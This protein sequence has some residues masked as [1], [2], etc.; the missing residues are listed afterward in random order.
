VSLRRPLGCRLPTLVD[1]SQDIDTDGVDSWV[2]FEMI[3]EDPTNVWL[4]GI[5]RYQISAHNWSV[6]G[7]IEAFL[8]EPESQVM[9][10][11]RRRKVNNRSVLSLCGLWKERHEPWMR[12]TKV[13]IRLNLYT[14]VQR[15]VKTYKSVSFVASR[16]KVKILPF[17]VSLIIRSKAVVTG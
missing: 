12:M 17:P 16:E 13:G 15:V 10:E 14:F 1:V 5:E 3:F 4:F 8:A 2:K 6:L 7:T 9:P 11:M